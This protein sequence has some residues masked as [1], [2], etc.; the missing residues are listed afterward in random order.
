MPIPL[1]GMPKRVFDVP[2]FLD[3]LKDMRESYEDFKSIYD[4]LFDRE[5]KRRRPQKGKLYRY[6]P[7]DLVLCALRTGT[8]S[9]LFARWEGPYVVSKKVHSL[10][11]EVTLVGLKP[12]T[13]KSQLPP[14]GKMTV[15]AER[16]ILLSSHVHV[17]DAATIT[18]L[19]R[20]ARLDSESFV[21]EK[22]LKHGI[23]PDDESKVVFQIKWEGFD[24]EEDH[25]WESEDNVKTVLGAAMKQYCERDESDSMLNRCLAR[26]KKWQT[27]GRLSKSKKRGRKRKN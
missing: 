16:M 26:Y 18:A 11:F 22:I 8:G 4:K 21:M 24:D 14:R 13:P 10:V 19:S 25:T 6:V 12:E 5:K 15:H 2:K 3:D 23:D 1:V 7:G 20:R 17:H 27:R 9:K